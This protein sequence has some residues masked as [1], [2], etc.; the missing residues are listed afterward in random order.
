MHHVISL[1][2]WLHEADRNFIQ[3]RHW[4]LNSYINLKIRKMGDFTNV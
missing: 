3:T 4:I 1:V 2:D